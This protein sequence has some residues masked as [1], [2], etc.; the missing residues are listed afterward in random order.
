MLACKKEDVL[1]CFK[2]NG[3]DEKEVRNPGFFETLLVRDNINV[4]VVK[5]TD[6]KVEIFAGK[7]LLPNVKTEI[8]D[9]VLIIEN[10]NTCNFVRGYKKRIVINIELPRIHEIVNRGVGLVSVESDFAQDTV[11][12]W[13]YGPGD[14]TL[15]GN[16][17]S[18][19]S[20]SHG[21]GD[22][23]LKGRCNFLHAYMFSTSFLKAE[24]LNVSDYVFVNTKSKGDCYLNC[25][26]LYKLEYNISDDGS[27]YYKGRPSVI[28]AIKNPESKGKALEL[29]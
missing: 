22:I 7:N 5:G 27:I 23:Y 29:N 20:I 28:E 26:G 6:Y 9:G 8:V 1:D 19:I 15:S 2:S 10:K 25:S 4:S 14:V 21:S 12:I 13:T 11:I 24:N 17:N 18:I 3:Q 16:Y